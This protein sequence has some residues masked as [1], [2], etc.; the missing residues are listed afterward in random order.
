MSRQARIA[1]IL[2]KRQN[3]GTKVVEANSYTQ[4]LLS[5]LIG[6]DELIKEY[7]AFDKSSEVQSNSVDSERIDTTNIR[8]ALNSEILR[9]ENL[10][11]RFSKPPLKIAVAGRPNEGKSTL[12]GAITGLPKKVIPSSPELCTGAPYTIYNHEDDETF[13]L[14]EFY[15]SD[16]FLKEVIQPYYEDSELSLSSKPTNLSTWQQPTL[17]RKGENAV[18]D[19][20]F[21]R[22]CD[23]YDTYSSYKEYLDKKSISVE[24][25]E[26][27]KYIAQVN[28]R[29]EKIHICRAVKSAVIY[30]KFPND[31][32]GE[33]ALL[34]TPGV[35]EIRVKEDEKLVEVLRKNSDIVICV[36]YP[37]SISYTFNQ[38]YAEFFSLMQK[39]IGKAEKRCL[40]ILN[41]DGTNSQACIELS[42]PEKLGQFSLKFAD[43]F[44]ANC[45]KPEEVGKN[46]VDPTLNYL[47][48]K[49]ESLDLD[50]I[51]NSFKIILEQC[52][53]STSVFE[54]ITV[55]S[56]DNT[57]SKYRELFDTSFVPKLN[58]AFKRMKKR[59]LEKDNGLS[60]KSIVRN[61]VNDLT[62][63]VPSAEDIEN[64]RKVNDDYDGVFLE[65]VGQLRLDVLKH[66][67]T[68]DLELKPLADEII[69]I[70]ADELRQTGLNKLST[71]K[72]GRDFLADISHLIPESCQKLKTYF[73][74]IQEFKLAY[75]W[76]IKVQIY[77]GLEILIPEKQKNNL[78]PQSE[79]LNRP[80]VTAQEVNQ[81]LQSI[82]TQV[83]SKLQGLLGGDSI[84]DFY[85][86]MAAKAALDE[87]I[88][89]SFYDYEVVDYKEVG[90]R[91]I[92]IVSGE[93]QKFIELYKSKIWVEDFEKLEKK[94]EMRDRLSKVIE[95]ARTSIVKLKLICDLEV[96][97]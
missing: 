41:D 38:D 45:T 17:E 12:I 51:G 28:E 30:T 49:I 90:K 87:F 39:G 60:V 84:D 19:T 88:D 96:A 46:V 7:E 10:H 54:K 48:K 78:K 8:S 55:E 35:G 65:V 26:I 69:E 9:L 29:N 77:E 5:S 3:W 93:W 32:V 27:Q 71:K 15:S 86:N 42:K 95:Q 56:S 50:D 63:S 57:G 2:A 67:L 97:S 68:L 44:I 92:G 11:Q 89:L 25:N 91:T 23:Y 14:V 62:F 13:A 6:L 73:Q 66:F 85:P 22:L 81:A 20:K 47:A 18:I 82:C 94:I 36:I 33:I 31:D 1:E 21:K 64:L 53:K 70:V 72:E 79:G 80:L 4:N 58:A 59:F 43:V 37:K 76:L 52:E 61:K 24:K 34:D 40:L 83:K 74:V 75:Y 16:D